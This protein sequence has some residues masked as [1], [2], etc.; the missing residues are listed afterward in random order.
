MPDDYSHIPRL[1]AY[2]RLWDLSVA[3]HPRDWRKQLRSLCALAR[4]YRRDHRRDYAKLPLGEKQFLKAL[5]SVD[6][7]D[8]IRT[9]ETDFPDEA[10]PL[11]RI[12]PHDPYVNREDYP[13]LY[14][15]QMNGKRYGHA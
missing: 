12:S 15:P 14:P 3:R 10:D 2:P 11:Q 8:L 1:V 13:G 6:I 7:S 5:S 4:V 9:L